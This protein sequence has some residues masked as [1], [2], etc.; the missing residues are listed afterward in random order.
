MALTQQ[1]LRA[2]DG[3]QGAP[4]SVQHPCA[5]RWDGIPLEKGTGWVSLGLVGQG[6]IQGMNTTSLLSLNSTYSSQ[7]REIQLLLLL[8]GPGTTIFPVPAVLVAL[9]Q[10]GRESLPVP[11][12]SGKFWV[13]FFLFQGAS[14]AQ[15][16]E[17]CP[18][19][20]FHLFLLASPALVRSG[21]WPGWNRLGI[22]FLT[23]S[24]PAGEVPSKN[25]KIKT[26]PGPH[27]QPEQGWN[28]MDRTSPSSAGGKILHPDGFSL[29]GA[30]KWKFP[31]IVE[32][33]TTD[34]GQI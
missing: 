31:L 3:S 7:V 13:G 34:T 19:V 28:G 5:E 33:V 32:G 12:C 24:G 30:G 4:G 18:C 25:Q 22:N 16:C 27:A 9:G 20:D 29:P 15:E 26:D 8:T 14:R 2:E 1:L 6:T 23:H 11:V 17:E 10:P 21:A